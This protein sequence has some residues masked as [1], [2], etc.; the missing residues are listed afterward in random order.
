MA[1]CV[2]GASKVVFIALVLA[3]GSRFLGEQVRIAVVV[4]SVMVL[5]FLAYALVSTFSTSRHVN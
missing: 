4:D 3:E 5:L 2:A 1:L